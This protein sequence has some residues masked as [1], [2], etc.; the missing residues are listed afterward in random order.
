[1]GGIEGDYNLDGMVDAADYTLWRD[2]LGSTLNLA[3]DGNQNGVVD[4]TDYGV[5]ASNYGQSIPAFSQAESQAVPEP[6]AC[7]M[8][9]TV[10]SFVNWRSRQA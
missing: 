7:V 5:W 4:S 2:S 3:A 10:M 8:L 6:S 9:L 1:M